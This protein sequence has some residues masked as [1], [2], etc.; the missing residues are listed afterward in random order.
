MKNVYRKKVAT[1]NSNPF[2]RFFK[3]EGIQFIFVN[4]WGSL[5]EILKMYFSGLKYLEKDVR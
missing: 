3:S 5:R 4:A 2:R 1:G